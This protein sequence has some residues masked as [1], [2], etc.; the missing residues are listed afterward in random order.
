[1]IDDAYSIQK[2]HYGAP[3]S[4]IKDAVCLVFFDFGRLKLASLGK[5]FYTM[6]FY[7]V[8]FSSHL[9]RRAI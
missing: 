1:M 9:G 2:L 5:T 6:L 8:N 4:M 3:L 7:G